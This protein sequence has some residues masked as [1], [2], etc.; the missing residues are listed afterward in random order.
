[1]T[2]Q[3]AKDRYSELNNEGHGFAVGNVDMTL[4]EAA[5]FEGW[6]VVERYDC[7]IVRALT[8]SGGTVLIGGDEYKRAPWAVRV[9]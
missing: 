6:R 1:M 4:T 3:E 2:E 5:T 7:G 8:E 9:V